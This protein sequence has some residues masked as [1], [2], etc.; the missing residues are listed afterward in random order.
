[1]KAFITLCLLCLTLGAMAGEHRKS[2]LGE[3][4]NLIPELGVNTTQ[5]SSVGSGPLTGFSGGLGIRLGRKK[6]IFTGIYYQNWKFSAALDGE[7]NP[8]STVSAGYYS[9]P[10]AIGFT[11]VKFNLFQLRAYA[12]VVGNF[13]NMGEVRDGAGNY[14]F[15]PNIWAGRIGAGFSI[16]RIE[17]HAAYD[18]AFEKLLE[19]G[20]NAKPRSLYIG[21][22][23][24]F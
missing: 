23:F 10:L 6:F 22:G 19:N 5:V 3:R 1:M 2:L 16:W 8:R 14:T 13:N 15:N 11:P 12:G 20:T 18:V 24:R 17:A 7:G 4:I 21:A 9:V